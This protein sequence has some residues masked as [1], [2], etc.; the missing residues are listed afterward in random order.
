MSGNTV[1][2][3]VGSPNKDGR[4]S[5][6]VSAALN[7]AA[8]AGAPT[9]L[10]QMSEHAVLAC[11]DCLPNVCPVN[12]KCTYKDEGFEFLADKIVDCGAL[13]LG[14]PVY[15]G[16]TSAMVKYLFVKMCRVYARAGKLRG[17]PAFGIAI[18]GGSG[19]GLTT[20]LRPIYHF[21]RAMQMRALDPLPATRF[22]FTEATRRAEELGSQVAGMARQRQPFDSPEECWLWYDRLPYIRED[23]AAERRLLAAI[24]LGAVPA[25]RK[26]AIEGDLARAEVLRASGQSLE[27]MRETSRV[28]DSS[29]KLIDQ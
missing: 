26:T 12:Q 21:Y 13:I 27:S 16:D 6:L 28:Y 18:A 5:Q 14:T 17:L 22:N 23:R 2:G 24:A 8:R 3:L 7:S 4:T 1:L 25:Q 29:V 19:N 20:S 9:E 15:W 11:K 10:V